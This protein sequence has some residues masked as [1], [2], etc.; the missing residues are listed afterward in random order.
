M[1]EDIG[2]RV[3]INILFFMC[4]MQTSK[5]WDDDRKMHNLI[6]IERKQ[7]SRPFF[8]LQSSRYI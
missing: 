7:R 2:E 3:K 6:F 1:T 5:Q 8:Y 4:S